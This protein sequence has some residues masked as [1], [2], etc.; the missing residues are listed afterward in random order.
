MKVTLKPKQV[1]VIIALISKIEPY[2]FKKRSPVL[3][4]GL[5]C[6]CTIFLNNISY[7]YALENV[8]QIQILF[9]LNQAISSCLNPASGLTSRLKFSHRF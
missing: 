8:I 4:A 5:F 9:V 2:Y 7:I 3:L 6:I 1:M